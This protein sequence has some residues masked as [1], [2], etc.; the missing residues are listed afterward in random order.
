[1]MYKIISVQNK[2]K[3]PKHVL[4][5]LLRDWMSLALSFL[6]TSEQLNCRLV[7]FSVKEGYQQCFANAGLEEKIRMLLPDGQMIPARALWELYGLD[8]WEIYGVEINNYLASA[9]YSQVLEGHIRFLEDNPDKRRLYIYAVLPNFSVYDM[10]EIMNEGNHRGIH[11][12]GKFY[13]KFSQAFFQNKS[14]KNEKPGV[15]SILMLKHPP[16]NS[17]SKTWPEQ[18]AVVPKGHYIPSAGEVIRLVCLF[19]HYTG[20]NLLKTVHVRTNTL[21]RIA[22]LEPV[23]DHPVFIG[24]FDAKGL[25]VG[26]C[27]AD[28]YLSTT[29]VAVA[30]MSKSISRRI[31]T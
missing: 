18:Q 31:V 25:R 28:L 29:G 5:Q 10:H 27:H 6:E 12:D 7:N 4:Y 23:T 19:K 20:E 30:R 2:T 9:E 24:L 14:W 21:V 16:K 11:K 26:I 17:F 13:H 8:L 1:M 15:G 22:P 3:K